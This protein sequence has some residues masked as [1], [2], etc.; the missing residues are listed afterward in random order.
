MQVLVD[1]RR[2][3]QKDAI[4]R[5]AIDQGVQDVRRVAALELDKIAAGVQH[6]G[7]AALAPP[8]KFLGLDDLVQDK[9]LV[10]VAL[11][12]IQ[13]PQNFGALVRS[14]VAIAGAAIIWG[15][16]ASAPLSPAMARTS[17]GAIE[18]ARLCRVQSLRDALR[19]LADAQVQ[20]IGLDPR[21]PTALHEIPLA[22]PTVLVIGSE[23]RGI[24][25][26]VRACC[27]AFARLLSAGTLDSL[28]AS[29]A[30]G[31]ALHTVLISRINSNG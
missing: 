11:D 20:V 25:R 21:A 23:H 26:G 10:A 27:T 29:V 2:T 19:C 1:A 30:A 18:Q 5:F 31:I 7:V 24:G 8:L 6:Q 17:A 16:H 15:E 3:P 4:E 14:A 12:E 13:D 28:N 9:N 22:G